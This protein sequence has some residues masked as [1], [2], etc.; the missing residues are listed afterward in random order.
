MERTDLA[1][2]LGGSPAVAEPA[3]GAVV[4]AERDPNRFL[5]AFA[6]AAAGRGPVFLADPL[7]TEA[8]RRELA[9]LI[10]AAGPNSSDLPGGGRGWLMVASGGTTGRIKFARHDEE[11]LAAAV[12]GFC[13]HFQVQRVDWLGLLPLHHV[14]GLLAWFRTLL[15]G[16]SYHPWDWK[17]LA[18]GDRPARPRGSSCYC[19]SL[20]ATQLQRLLA[21]PAAA[22]WLRGFDLV[23]LGGGPGWPELL[24]AA[25]RE[26][27]ALSISYGMTE[28]AAMV[29]AL[30]PA[31]FA[32]GARSCGRA[33]PHARIMVGPDGR[34]SVDGPS[35]F[36]GYFPAWR[37]PGLFAT[38]DLG[39]WD[40]EGRLRILGRRDAVIITGGKKVDPAEVEA[41]LRASGEFADV[42]V[43]GLADPEW[44]QSVTACY[45][46]EQRPPDLVRVAGLLAGLAT[47]KRPRR[48]LPA[49]P[50]PRNA[51]GKL[52]RAALQAALEPP[53]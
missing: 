36:R 25:A 5:E 38:E 49:E 8:E 3:A 42:A 17:R 15:T 4:I 21:E 39:R 50:W 44:G 7:W 22:E 28:T 13:A 43:I 23:F 10:A 18:A 29:A 20:V 6:R 14:S 24:E 1:R 45:P 46:A 26:R 41:V 19:V 52:N 9:A 12:V 11:T 30:R 37:S 31:E 34:L 47:F 2:L 53:A 48:Y 33:L 27:I 40:E 51:Q 35:L 32:A 16:G